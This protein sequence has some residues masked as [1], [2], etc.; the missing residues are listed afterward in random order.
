MIPADV[1]ADGYL[2][3]LTIVIILAIVVAVIL[4]GES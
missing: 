2:T 4:R 3:V 1:W